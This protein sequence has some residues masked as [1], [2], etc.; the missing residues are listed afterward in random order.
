MKSI[1]FSI[2]QSQGQQMAL[3]SAKKGVKK[4]MRKAKVIVPG[5]A[6]KGIKAIAKNPGKAGLAMAGLAAAGGL[7]IAGAKAIGNA[8]KPKS[9]TDRLKNASKKMFK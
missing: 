1:N 6:K 4:G 7:G 2:A 8:R 5:L 3:D 9:L